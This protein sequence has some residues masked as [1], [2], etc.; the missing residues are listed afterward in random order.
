[1][2][3]NEARLSWTNETRL[4]RSTLP[5]HRIILFFTPSLQL[6]SWN[7]L[8]P[9]H[10]QENTSAHFF[11]TWLVIFTPATMLTI[12]VLPILAFFSFA[13]AQTGILGGTPLFDNTTCVTGPN[14]T[15]TNCNTFYS[16]LGNCTSNTTTAALV[17]CE[18]KQ[19]F[20]DLI[21]EYVSRSVKLLS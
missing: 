5:Y 18:C 2:P 14:T 17:D 8:L 11:P 6:S 10:V 3:S 21:I 19:S 13:A 7:C 20:F 1:M 16:T 12:V 4:W 15:F 9:H